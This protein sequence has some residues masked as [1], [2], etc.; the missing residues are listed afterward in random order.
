[1]TVDLL[2]ELH[3]R[4]MRADR[5]AQNAAAMHSQTVHLQAVAKRAAYQDAIDLVIKHMG[6][7]PER[8]AAS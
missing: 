4:M 1:M 7:T 6:V 3:S 8:E 5:D 2:G